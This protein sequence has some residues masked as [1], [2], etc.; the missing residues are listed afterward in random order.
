MKVSNLLMIGLL[1]FLAV[2][3]LR[4]PKKEGMRYLSQ[5]DTHDH[6]KNVPGVYPVPYSATTAYYQIRRDRGE[7]YIPSF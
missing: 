2:L 4:C 5:Y 7:A 6:V 3:F 1:V